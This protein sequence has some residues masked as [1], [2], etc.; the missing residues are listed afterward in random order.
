MDFALNNLQ[1][2]IYYKTQPTNLYS[3]RATK[4]NSR[5]SG[6]AILKGKKKSAKFTRQQS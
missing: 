3:P 4:L 6:A 5:V 1:R 2:S